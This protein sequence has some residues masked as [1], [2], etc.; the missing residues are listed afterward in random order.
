MKKILKT[1]ACA[2]LCCCLVLPAAGCKKSG[3]DPESR[4][5]KLAT[6]ALDGNFNPYTYT[7]QTDGDVLGMTQVGMF[8]NDADGALICGQNEAT[9]ALNYATTMY[10]RRSGGNV[11]ANGTADG[12]TEYEIVIKNGIK[13]SDGVD[14]TIKDVLFNLY[15]YLDVAYVGSS[16]IYSTDIQGLNAYRAQDPTLTDDV[17]SD[18]SATF[19]S[20]ALER[21]YKILDWLEYSSSNEIEPTDAQIKADLETTKKLF[22]EE[23]ESDWV[24]VESSWSTNFKD[25]NFTAAWQA[26]LFQEQIAWVQ[27]RLNT[28]TNSAEQI[29]DANDKFVTTLEPNVAGANNVTGATGEIHLQDYIDLLNAATTDDKVAEYA[30]AHNCDKEYALLQL[31]KEYCIEVVYENFTEKSQIGNVLQ[32]WATATSVMQELAAQ[33]RTKYFNDLRDRGIKV[34][35]ISGITT[36]KATGAELKASNK[37]WKMTGETFNDGESYSVLKVVINGIDPKAIFNLAFTVAPLHYYSGEWTNPVTGEK[38]DY[39][40]AAMEDTENKEFG[41]QVGNSTFFTEVISATAKNGLPVGAGPY[42]ASTRNGG[43]ATDRSEFFNSGVVNYERNIYFETLGTGIENAKIKVLRY[44]VTTDDQV[45]TS[46]KTGVIDYGTPNANAENQ[47]T[48]TS[49]KNLTPLPYRE[50]GYGYVGINPKFVPEVQVRQAIMMAMNTRSII[51]DYYRGGLAENIWRPMTKESWAY[52]ETAT[53][54]PATAY[55]TDDNKIIAL[56][57]EAGY[58]KGS[59]GIYAKNGKKLKITFTIAGS[60]SDHPAY[61]MFTMARDRLNQIGFDVSV[62][63]SSTALR[64]MTRGNLAVW[65]AAWSSAIDPD[66]Y[67]VY[68]KD[69]KAT[70]VNNWNYPE[71]LNPSNTQ[72]S[73]ERSIVEELSKKIDEG[74]SYLEKSDRIPIYAECLDLIMQLAVELPTY[75]RKQL[76]VFN[77]KVLDRNTMTKEPSAYDGPISEIWKLNYVK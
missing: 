42:M 44:Q 75:Q 15:V 25:Y 46:L 34:D 36:Y 2:G 6:A 65:A 18:I 5:L 9:V 57:K 38:K 67:Q 51:Q 76:C 70:S 17:D 28:T 55:T 52:P 21:V 19:N 49:T 71:I 45:M 50:G 13:F 74:R 77:N 14:L 4:A 68:H 61:K 69:S 39:V 11:T 43:A 48:A 56:V 58:E 10:D 59:D 32:Y 3:L 29:K 30:S 7:S 12:R 54:N 41:V 16:T 37:G 8:T 73:Y 22:R 26:Y 64:D 1:V 31:Q 53:E 60:S 63:T 62:S 27:T 47:N 20:A 72:F 24:D 33:E 35:N 23:I 40:K 66:P